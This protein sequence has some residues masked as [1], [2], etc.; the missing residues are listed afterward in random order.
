MRQSDGN[1]SLIPY[2]FQIGSIVEWKG[3]RGYSAQP[4]AKAIVTGIGSEFL[5]VKWARNELSRSQND[6]G[7]LPEDFTVFTLYPDTLKNKLKFLH[8]NRFI[9]NLEYLE[10]LSEK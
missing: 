2:E 9:S 4:G 7:Y 8:K 3:K 10:A 1:K 6:G 5:Y